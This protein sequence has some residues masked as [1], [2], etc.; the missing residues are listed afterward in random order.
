MKTG[1]MWRKKKQQS[2]GG[3]EAE[4]FKWWLEQPGKRWIN[5]IWGIKKMEKRALSYSEFLFW[6]ETWLGNCLIEQK[7]KNKN[8]T[9]YSS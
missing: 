6:R 2:E 9:E 7:K 5:T 4:I 3:K 1:E 8:S